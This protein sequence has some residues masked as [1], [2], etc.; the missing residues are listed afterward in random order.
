MFK[1]RK[2][3]LIKEAKSLDC[4]ILAPTTPENIFYTTGFWGTGIALI[5][6]DG[7]TTLFT[8]SLE[9]GLAKLRAKECEVMIVEFEGLKNIFDRIGLNSKICFDSTPIFLRKKIE[10]I[11]ITR[12]TFDP[13]VFYSVRKIK[14]EAEQSILKQGVKLVDEIF[15]DMVTR[16]KPGLREREIAAEIISKIISSGGDLPSFPSTLN[17]IIVAS[18]SNSIFPHAELSNRKLL[19]GDPVIIDITFRFLGY[20]ID[21]TRTFIIKR[22]SNGVKKIYEIVKD[23][24]EEG[25]KKVKPFVRSG[26]LDRI[27]R[28]KIKKEGFEKFFIHSTGHGLGL[29]VHEPPYIRRNGKETLQFNELITIEPGIYLNKF[30]I[31]IEDMVMIN[32]KPISMSKFTK[33]LVVVG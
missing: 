17:P 6:E 1:Q 20:V 12:P 32:N 3:S 8:N 4:C 33:E 5:E 30:G 16:L 13:N 14:S 31:R 25:I 28:G 19:I 10:K 11:L 29:E 7:N 23:A 26:E 18:G 2:K 22:V 15:G 24:Q 9:G 27:V 21:M